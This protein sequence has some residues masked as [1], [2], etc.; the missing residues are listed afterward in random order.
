MRKGVSKEVQEL[1]NKSHPQDPA[2][3]LPVRTTDS[4]NKSKKLS[5]GRSK[6]APLAKELRDK[7][8]R[9]KKDVMLLKDRVDKVVNKQEKDYNHTKSSIK[10]LSRSIRAQ[11][12]L[13][14]NGLDKIEK[15]YDIKNNTSSIINS[16][17]DLE[18]FVD[19]SVAKA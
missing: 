12:D 17:Q 5:S 6:F 1:A 18:S 16:K 15:K 3:N 2:Y 13:I 9:N 7:S 19:R 8:F 4:S 14:K 11:S 10:S